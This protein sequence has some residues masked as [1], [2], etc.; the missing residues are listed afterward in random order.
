MAG[1]M[2]LEPPIQVLIQQDFHS[3]RFENP[4]PRLFEYRNDL[5]ASHSPKTFE[6]IID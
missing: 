6:K 3:S 4:T 2:A 5:F 1:Q